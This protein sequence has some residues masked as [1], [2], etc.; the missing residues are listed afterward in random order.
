M[1][2]P[3][4]TSADLWSMACL[5]FELATGDLLFDPHAGGAY[6]RDE[7]STTAL[8]SAVSRWVACSQPGRMCCRTIWRC[9]W[10]C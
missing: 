6:E 2:A 10:S 3:Y 4:C 9:S 8:A 1:G 7:V 5:V